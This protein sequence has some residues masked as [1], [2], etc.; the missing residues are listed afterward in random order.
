M[1]LF[2]FALSVKITHNALFFDIFRQIF[3]EKS[4]SVRAACATG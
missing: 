4:N 3:N 1:S 2:R